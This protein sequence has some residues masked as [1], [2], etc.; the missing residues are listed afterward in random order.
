ML[1]T[2]PGIVRLRTTVV[3][4]S[5]GL[6][7]VAGASGPAR[8]Q[9]FSIGAN[10]TSMTYTQSTGEPPDTMA[11]VGPNY[12]VVSQ[13]DGFSIFNKRGVLVSSESPAA[14]WTSA[15]GSNPG[16]LTDPRILY[17]PASQRWFA[18]MVTT[19]QSTDNKIL[20]ARSNSAD[21]TQGFK[22]V[23]YTTTNNRFAD[24]PTLGLDANGLYVG[25][26]NFSGGGL[27]RSEG[28]YS[29]PKA[30]LL[31][32]TPTLARLTSFSVL[33]ASTV[34][35]TLQ[36]AVNYGP[37]QPTDPEI[38]LAN[39]FTS[40]TR[41]NFTPL[42]G[43]SGAGA[44]VGSTTLKTVQS[45]SNPTNSAQPGSSNTIDNGDDSF[46]SNVVQIGNFLYAVNSTALSGRTAVR[47][48]IANAASFNIV[49][50][51][52][53]SD[54][55]LSFFYPSIAVNA[56]GDV[57][58]GFS[59]S[60]SSTYASTYAVVGNQRAE[61]RADRSHSGRP[62]RRS[63]AAPITMATAGAISARRHPIRPT[64]ASSGR[65][66]SMRRRGSFPALIGTGPQRQPRS[67]RQRRASDDGRT[68]PAAASPR[69]GIT[70]QVRRPWRPTTSSSV[71]RARRTRLRFR[72]AG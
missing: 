63:L 38:I 42:N 32:A 66:K 33:N 67:F 56:A 13:N 1:R 25:T 28:L 15:L 20:F 22:G 65:T 7:A 36:A 12:F 18:V 61:S 29:V 11:A 3:A 31:A 23:S 24:F 47:W 10:F 14:F 51:G 72:A 57:V 37:K 17:D 58:V 50:Q 16:G 49:Q 39:N 21:P 40:S 35:F 54:P 19:D 55:A 2:A 30:D 27:F 59:G 43:T 68:R 53:I 9:T 48:T 26:N 69:A 44:T 64:P 5:V 34:G 46:S 45:T 70:S 71:G 62:S 6:A 8:G 41:Y 4:L 52:T 60:N